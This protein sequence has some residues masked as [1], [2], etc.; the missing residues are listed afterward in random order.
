MVDATKMNFFL[1]TKPEMFSP[2]DPVKRIRPIK[3][4]EY[5]IVI[6]EKSCNTVKKILRN[7]NFQEKHSF[8]YKICYLM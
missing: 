5:T 4:K 6:I 2:V 7:N 8:E 3:H 1:N